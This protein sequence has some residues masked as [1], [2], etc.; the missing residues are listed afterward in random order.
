[1]SDVI[2]MDARRAALTGLGELMQAAME[3][4]DDSGDETWHITKPGVYDIIPEWAYLKDPVE[5]GSLSASGAK[6]LLPPSCPALFDWW[7]THPRPP[8]DAYDLGHAA[9]QMVLGAGPEI[10]ELRFDDWRTTAARTA[11]D[12]V[13]AAGKVPLL[14]KDYTRAVAMADAVRAHPLA[15]RIFD[16]DYGEPEQTLVW[17]DLETG[18]NCRGRVDW[19]PVT[20]PGSRLII[21]D[22]KTA[23]CA[24]TRTFAR[25][26]ANYGYPQQNA[27]YIDGAK[28]LGLDEDPAFVFVVV[29]NQPPHLV[30]IIELDPPSI[31]AGRRRNRLALEI[32]RECQETGVW[33]GY[34]DDVELASVPFWYLTDPTPTKEYA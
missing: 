19:L 22:F 14:T 4:D 11:R 6:M 24:E 16:P 28:A 23:D 10:V 33:P 8:K 20:L 29:E 32:Y 30:N 31:D 18:V 12:E 34:A 2:D 3:P 9:H 27:H 7:R 26:A 15:S 13:R 25:A 1:M 17:Q 5:G 21:P